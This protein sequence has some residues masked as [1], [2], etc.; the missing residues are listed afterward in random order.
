MWHDLLCLGKTLLLT[1]ILVAF[2]LHCSR[3][4]QALHSLRRSTRYEAEMHDLQM[5]VT[6]GNEERFFGGQAGLLEA[7]LPIFCYHILF[8]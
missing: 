8:N 7:T 4:V 6:A 5:V 3:K 1:Y 2:M